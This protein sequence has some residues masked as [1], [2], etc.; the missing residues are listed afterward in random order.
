MV[1]IVIIKLF[2]VKHV[3]IKTIFIKSV[4]IL[5]VETKAYSVVAPVVLPIDILIIGWCDPKNRRLIK[6]YQL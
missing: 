1:V 5:V 3:F 4:F 6:R 2:F